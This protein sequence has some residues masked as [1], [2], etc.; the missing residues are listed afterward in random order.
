MQGMKRGIPHYMPQVYNNLC[1]KYTTFYATDTPRYILV[2]R[3]H[4][5]QFCAYEMGIR[6]PARRPLSLPAPF[7]SSLGIFLFIGT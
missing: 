2:V 5:C 1:P 7:F 3:R 6:Y 4:M